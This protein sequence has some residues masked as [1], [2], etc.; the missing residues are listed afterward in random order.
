MREITKA[1]IVATLWSASPLKFHR[2]SVLVGKNVSKSF[3]AVD[4]FSSLNFTV[5]RGDKVA[6][7]GPNGCGK[8]TLLRIIAGTDEANGGSAISF[9]RGITR[10]YLS[11][12]AEDSADS[13][14]WQ[15][16]QSAFTE[17]RTLQERL[18]RLEQEMLDPARAER[19]LEQYGQVQH[20]FET[21]GG[22]EIDAR[23]KRVLSG[24]GF[25]EEQFHTPLA[26]LSGGQRVRAALARLLLLSPDVLLLDEPTNHLDTD[27]VE[28]LESFLQ[29]WEGT[30]IVVSHDRYFIDEV[31][32]HIW[33]MHH[34][35]DDQSLLDDYHGSYTD[36]VLQRDAGFGRYL[37]AR[38]D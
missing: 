4:V 37:L 21:R 7:V 26:R 25:R 38:K 36:F 2:M 18:N 23:V 5:A 6:L 17:L 30:L 28:W 12:T 32:D 31:C 33:D 27:G 14:I 8:T 15:E 35:S 34:G 3:G 16:T 29:E 24:L 20:E 19:A 10:G 11:Q 22:Y 1:C 9:A 13:T